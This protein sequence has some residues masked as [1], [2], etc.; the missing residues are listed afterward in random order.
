MQR[1]DIDTD[2]LW[3]T[4]TPVETLTPEEIDELTTT[5]ADP[6]VPVVPV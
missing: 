1:Q 3:T 2:L 6:A 5:M 4:H